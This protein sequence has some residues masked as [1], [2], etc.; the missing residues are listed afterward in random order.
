[1]VRTH[2]WTWFYI[3]VETMA[4]V[5][6]AAAAAG[7]AEQ[8]R[9][10]G[11]TVT[12]RLV[13]ADPS[14]AVADAPAARHAA[15]V[16]VPR[17]REYVLPIEADSTLTF[18]VTSEGMEGAPAGRLQTFGSVALTGAT[19][20]RSL[21]DWV[22]EPAG[23]GLE[24][25]RLRATRNGEAGS[26]VLERVK[27][28]FD[29][30]GQRYTLHADILRPGVELA[31]RM[32][33]P[34]L[35]QR[36]LGSVT[37]EAMA[38]WVAGDAPPAAEPQP[39]ATGARSV[40]ADM[41]FC[42]LYGLAQYGRV[43]EIVG[44]ALAT[45]SWN[46][47][48]ADISWLPMPNEHH[49]FIAM[50]LYRVKNDR[51]EQIGQSWVKHAFYALGNTQCGG[52][53]TFEP[54]HVYGEYLGIGCTDTYSAPLNG[55]QNGMGPRYEINPWTGAWT[56]AGSHNSVG[57]HAH[58]GIEH[59]VQVRDADL[60]P[61]Q[62]AGANYFAEGYYVIAED[63]NV[64]NSIAWKPVTVSGAPGGT[65]SFVM[66]AAGTMPVAG[67]AL[68]AWPGTRQ[69]EFAQEVPPVEFVSPDGR[70][71]LAAQV[72]QRAENIWRYT[73]ALMNVDM[74]RQVG[75]FTVPLATGAHVTS[76]GFHAVRHHDEP[77]N[78]VGGV[79]IDNAAWTADVSTSAVTFSTTTNPLRWGTVYTF[80]FDADSGPGDCAAVL[81]LFK[82]GTPATVAGQTD[83]PVGSPPVCGNGQVEGSEECDP[84]DGTTCDLLCQRIPICG[85]SLLDGDEQC[86]P[87]DGA[88]CAP[89]CHWV[90]GDGVIQAGEECDPPD[91]VNCDSNCLTTLVCGNSVVQA[92][93]QCD[94]GNA[95][96]GDGCSADCQFEYHDN[97]AQA[98]MI[99]EGVYTFD[100]TGKD[101]DG[102][103]HEACDSYNGNTYYDIWYR[104]SPSCT[105]DMTVSLCNSTFDTNLVIYDGCTC[106]VDD[107]RLMVCADEGC[108]GTYPVTDRSVA[109][110][111]VVAGHCYLVRI[112][113]GYVSAWGAGE[114]VLTC[115]DS[116]A[117]PLR[118]GQLWD[119]WW[120][121]NHAAMPT[122]T[123][124]LYPPDGLQESAATQR[125]GECHGW[126][127][128]GVDGAYASGPH[129][130]G[131]KGVYGS[132]L[133]ASEMFDL[134][135]S[136]AAPNG[137]GFGA[138]GLNDYDIRDLVAFLQTQV[139]DT[140]TYI[141]TNG[142]FVGDADWGQVY[143]EMEGGANERCVDC[144][145]FNGTQRNFGSIPGPEWVGT[146]AGEDPARLL[147]K[148]RFGSPGTPMPG[149]I[150]TGHTTQQAADI[151]RYAQSFPRH[152]L[153]DL[154]C[155]D[156]DFCNGE[157]TCLDDTC[158]PGTA[159]PCA[160]G[161][162][163]CNGNGVDDRCD[164]PGD[165]DLDGA[166]G[167]DDFAR[168]LACQTS[169]CVGGDCAPFLYA[170]PC[171]V[172]VDVDRDGD[173]DL[174]DFSAFQQV[175]DAGD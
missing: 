89:N 5:L 59:R 60:D 103:G 110:V 46:I 129:H 41:T 97:C 34:A 6:G 128:K 162:I 117:D 109:T 32:G 73:Y 63:I 139:I 107:N 99:G 163:D 115:D 134:I 56:F 92:G 17:Y 137:H 100:T 91:G 144:H 131:I 2:R 68:D 159:P 16:A 142:L 8:W 143:Y 83:G 43:G 7:G 19:G 67:L 104:V 113:G 38:D 57:T 75:S 152:C 42:Q 27:A 14:E 87:P 51:F 158:L 70:C 102:P 120:L 81:G 98:G 132:T 171:C 21:G 82:P 130:T 1:M 121:V 66:S 61:A 12:V 58:D 124:P 168:M 77:V 149:W 72:T 157:E 116:Q 86:D 140:N 161:C 48:D 49:P 151:G 65:W 94:D 36:D 31:R 125:C 13:D 30:A 44:L 108:P 55:A 9:V 39:R 119:T 133:T 76:V 35:A 170:D 167:L 62:N 96:G 150:A 10:T 80:W 40:G 79:P 148:I 52:T 23:E 138:L 160:A 123:H 29:H 26:F 105:G 106:P 126:D 4:V 122:A 173:V 69:T 166:V 164:P 25:M 145:G 90:C 64:M 112:G 54:G 11:G 169:C 71:V 141:D 28:G 18:R 136:D 114:M 45:T 154:H 93:E 95:I 24:G 37:V 15:E 85:D 22:L 78:A 175:F 135:K 3:I 147:H 153:K 146:I 53:C 118:G 101:I 50:N 172:S 155:D 74:D 127:Y 111:P 47:G 84:P 165:F 33:D 174:A 20:T 88:H 156:G